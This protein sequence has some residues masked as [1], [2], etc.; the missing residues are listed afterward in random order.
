M[1]LTKSNVS[2]E[3][4]RPDSSNGHLHECVVEDG[5][6]HWLALYGNAML[7]SISSL[8]NV[9]A[10]RSGICSCRCYVEFVI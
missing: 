2:D 6:G 4:A 8:P 7:F 5:W 1:N 3:S 10:K 9:N